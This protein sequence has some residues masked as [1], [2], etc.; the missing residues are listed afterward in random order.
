MH[1]TAYVSTQAQLAWAED[2]GC[3]E[4]LIP[5]NGFSREEGFDLKDCPALLAESQQRGLEPILMAD[6]LVEQAG[7]EALLARMLE[8]PFK[9]IRVSDCGLAQRL[10]AQSRKVQLSLESGHANFEALQAWVSLMPQLDRVVLNH[11]IP[12]RNLLPLLPKLKLETE[13]LGLGPIAMYYTPRKLLSIQGCG[14]KE[15]LIH[16]DEMGPGQYRLAESE[17]GTVMHYDKWLCLLPHRE[18]LQQAG[19]S[20]L[21]LDLRFVQAQEL[22]ALKTALQD[23]NFSLRKAWER[24]LLHGF[25]GENKSDS[26]FSKLVGRRPDMERSVLGEVMDRVASRLLVLLQKNCALGDWVGAQHGRGDWLKWDLDELWTPQ[27]EPLLA[28]KAGQLVL[29]KRPKNLAVGTYLYRESES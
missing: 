1:F 28:A 17:A 2:L 11:Q 27:G 26:I 4:V 16:S 7:F 25:Y 9:S 5:L 15:S 24:P 6:R 3:A 14:S 10:L 18:E 8:L 13:L 29:M 20:H 12:R 19:L 23:V 22:E 21:R